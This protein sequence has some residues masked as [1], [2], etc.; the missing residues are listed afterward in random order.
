ME[1]IEQGAVHEDSG[2][3][4]RCRP[5]DKLTEETS[6][7]EAENLSRENEHYLVTEWGL[8]VIEDPLRCDDIRAI[9]SAA[10]DE[11]VG[12]DGNADMFLDIER[13]WI[14]RPDA[15]EQTEACRWKYSLESLSE[16]E[17]NNLHDDAREIDRRVYEIS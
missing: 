4:H 12:H 6:E 1:C 15:A 8:L 11:D 16:R 2:P 14:Q 17:R 10:G 7:G 9:C 13:A 5:D 3:D